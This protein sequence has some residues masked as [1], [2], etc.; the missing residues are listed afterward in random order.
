VKHKL[1]ERQACQ[2]L[3]I[4]RTALRHQ[5]KQVNDTEIEKLLIEISEWKP[6]WGCTKMYNYL[7]NQGYNWNHKKILRI[8]RQLGLNIKKK[9]K[10]RYPTR[11]PVPLF[12]PKHSNISW[13]MD[14]MS[15][16]LDNGKKFRALNIIDDFNRE[17]LEIEIDYSLPSLRVIRVLEKIAFWRGFPK[18]IRLDNGPEYISKKLM[19][20]AEKRNIRLAYIQPGKPAQ[21]GYVERFNRTYREDILDAYI[22]SSLNEV[23]LLTQDWVEEYNS[24]RPHDSL[25]GVSPH[26]FVALHT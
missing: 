7:R 24:I 8:Y 25:Q 20:W 17:C 10:R 3:G 26:Q 2:F 15:D 13:S 14:F 1:S 21:N 16:S 6:R 11:H 9:P 4:S 23:R 18:Q 22:F 5:P 19:E 12:V